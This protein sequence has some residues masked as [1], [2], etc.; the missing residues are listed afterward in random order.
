MNS[1]PALPDHQSTPADQAGARSA[2]TSRIEAL[3]LVRLLAIVG[4]MATHLL[5]PLSMTPE[6][7]GPESAAARIAGVLAE[8]TSSTLFAVVGGCSLVLA[9]RTRLLAGDRRGAVLAGVL[10]GALVTGLGLLLEMVPTSVVVVLVPFGL[11]MMLTAPLLLVP[12]RVLLLMVALL[13]VIGGPL[14]ALVPGRVELG[15]VTLLSLDDPV[16]T[17]RGLLLT[18]MYPVITW[19]PYLL[20]GVVLMRYLLRAQAAGRTARRTLLAVAT[21]SALALIGHGLEL[22]AGALGS[23]RPGAWYMATAHTGTV[24]D[25]AATAGVSVALIAAATYLL[26]PHRHVQT[27]ILRSLRA[28]GAAPLTIYVTHVLLTGVAVIGYALTS[29]GDPAE[30]PWYV[31]GTGILGVHLAL[32]VCFGALL[33]ATGRQGP[34][35]GLISRLVRR[36]VPPRS[37]CWD[38]AQVRRPCGSAHLTSGAAHDPRTVAARHR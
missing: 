7:A 11:G 18:G 2:L 9:A 22:T 16:G 14:R 35:E 37:A 12:S 28:A 24:A 25:M 33:A 34:L 6:A 1:A 17:A 19:V 3:D 32:V 13:S 31:A 36:V 29:G 4:M 21:G 27:G 30:M 38:D 5:V 20:L 23:S 26:P 10:R 8:G 15:A